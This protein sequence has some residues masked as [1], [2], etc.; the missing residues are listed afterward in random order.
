M[1]GDVEK[2]AAE[3]AVRIV[4]SDLVPDHEDNSLCYS[5]GHCITLH[6]LT[7]ISQIET[8]TAIAGQ[9]TVE[10]SIATAVNE[11][12]KM[13][14][15]LVEQDAQH[16]KSTDVEKVL[17]VLE[18]Q[19]LALLAK[20]LRVQVNFRKDDVRL[21][22][23]GQLSDRPLRLSA[24]LDGV[25]VVCIPSLTSAKDHN[26]KLPRHIIIYSKISAM[27]VVHPFYGI[28]ETDDPRFKHWA[29]MQDLSPYQSL[30]QAIQGKTLPKN[31]PERLKIAYELSKTVA[32]LHSVEVLIKSMTD[33][34][35][36]MRPIEE[37]GVEPVLTNL[38]AAREVRKSLLPKN[39]KEIDE[40][41]Q[42]LEQTTG[43]AYDVRYEAP[44]YAATSTH[45]IHT[46]IWCLGV[47]I[48]Q[49]VTEMA[50]LGI[51]EPIAKDDPC[52]AALRDRIK[53]SNFEK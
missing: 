28:A 29:V 18:E 46:D 38:E 49:I 2:A 32:Y 31:L 13:A 9:K 36:I 21:K 37:K 14:R 7:I 11:T 8:R 10:N 43:E 5:D 30:E 35:I 27:T 44:E 26:S 6:L 39:L 15:K 23:S 16:A 33:T 22:I 47:L 40:S 52:A 53:K 42:F 3:D 34:N 19:N 20:S 25:R 51:P 24:T 45:S 1:G 4:K 17:A 12:E 41:L 50:P 48:I